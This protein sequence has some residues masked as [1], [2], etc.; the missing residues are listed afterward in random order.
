MWIHLDNELTYIF[1]LDY[2][3]DKNLRL[4]VVQFDHNA[5]DH[6]LHTIPDQFPTDKSFNVFTNRND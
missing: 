3:A 2:L 1:Q 5:L 6:F 4:Q